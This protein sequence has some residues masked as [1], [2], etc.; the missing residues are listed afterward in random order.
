[1][2][3]F[4]AEARVDLCRCYPKSP[5]FEPCPD[6]RRVFGWVHEAAEILKNRAQEAGEA[7]RSRYRAH[8]ERIAEQAPSAGALRSSIF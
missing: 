4:P 8:L 5:L 2:P 7:L 6:L 3:R 1:M